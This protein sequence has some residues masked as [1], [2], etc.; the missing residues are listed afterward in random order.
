MSGLKVLLFNF[1]CVQLLLDSAARLDTATAPVS[2]CFYTC[3]YCILFRYSLHC[4]SLQS[5]PA[6]HLSNCLPCFRDTRR[7]VT[8]MGGNPY[9]VSAHLRLPTSGVVVKSRFE[10]FYKQRLPQGCPTSSSNSNSKTSS[11]SSSSATTTSK[12]N[13][14]NSSNSNNS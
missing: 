13:S 3:V 14:N 1:S 11:S 12:N 5:P 7:L 4:S 10:P 8:C 2:W 6:F 9:G